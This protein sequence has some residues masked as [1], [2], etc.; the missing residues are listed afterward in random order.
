MHVWV[1]EINSLVQQNGFFHPTI[2]SLPPPLFKV[3]YH[4]CI[5]TAENMHTRML[6]SLCGW[7]LSLLDIAILPK[8][9]TEVAIIHAHEKHGIHNAPLLDCLRPQDKS[10]I[11]ISLYYLTLFCCKCTNVAIQLSVKG[12]RQKCKY[13]IKVHAENHTLSNY[14]LFDCNNKPLQDESISTA[15]LLL[16]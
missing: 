15:Y 14:S 1:K 6:C 3:C 5:R 7:G 12:V 16:V 4:W 2:Q 9:F 11:Y 8:C 13:A 10:Y